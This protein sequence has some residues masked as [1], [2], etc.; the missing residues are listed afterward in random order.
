MEAFFL[1]RA[2]LG[3]VYSSSR[4]VAWKGLEFD[5]HPPFHPRRARWT[6]GARLEGNVRLRGSMPRLLSGERF[7][8]PWTQKT[9]L[10]LLERRRLRLLSRA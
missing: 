1:D 4:R 3:L 2:S 8:L 5:P 6:L 9:G 7:A 10:F